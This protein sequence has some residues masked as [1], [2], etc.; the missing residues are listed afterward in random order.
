MEKVYYISAKMICPGL[1]SDP[2]D[3]TIQVLADCE[4]NAKRAAISDVL[5]MDGIITKVYACD[6]VCEI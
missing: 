3:V 1:C 2:F 5:Q 6:L 4:E